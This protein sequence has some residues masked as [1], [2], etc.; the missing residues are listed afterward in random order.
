MTLAANMELICP[1]PVQTSDEKTLTF[2]NQL[3]DHSGLPRSYQDKIPCV[4]PVFSL[5]SL[6]FPCVFSSTKK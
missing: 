4:F 6:L 2:I 3:R 5:C 1:G